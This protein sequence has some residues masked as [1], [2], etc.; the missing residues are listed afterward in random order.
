LT[1]ERHPTI[2]AL[3][4]SQAVGWRVDRLPEKNPYRKRANQL[5]TG[6]PVPSLIG[7]ALGSKI[8]YIVY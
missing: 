4:R 3:N 5:L 2:D 1:G 6:M 7:T 8:P